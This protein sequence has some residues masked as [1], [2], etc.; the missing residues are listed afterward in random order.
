MVRSLLWARPALHPNPVAAPRPLFPAGTTQGHVSG[1][2]RSPLPSTP[3][4]ISLEASCACCWNPTPTAAQTSKSG[5]TSTASRGSSSDEIPLDKTDFERSLENQARVYTK[6]DP[7]VVTTYAEAIKRGD[8]FP[9]V[10]AHRSSPTAKL[11][12][13]DGN[14]AA[15]RT[16]CVLPEL[17]L[18]R[19]GQPRR[20]EFRS[21]ADTCRSPQGRLVTEVDVT[22]L[23]EPWAPA[24]D[25]VRL[26]TSRKSPL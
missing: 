6:L 14:R 24:A 21:C 19:H 1:N 20:L 4:R 12:N 7:E 25:P 26:R 15:A 23:P 16:S 18:S 9:A 2:F 8:Q 13:V 11:R 17:P 5:W 10:V 22:A 3:P